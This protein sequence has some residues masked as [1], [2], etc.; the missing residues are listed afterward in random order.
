MCYLE[1]RYPSRSLFL[2]CRHFQMRIFFLSCPLPPPQPPLSDRKVFIFC[3]M[4]DALGVG[5][6]KEGPVA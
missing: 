4:C 3:F 5:F 6:V 1:V 2:Q